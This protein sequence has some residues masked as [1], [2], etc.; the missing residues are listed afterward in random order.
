MLN[1]ND[2]VV[3]ALELIDAR[4]E[5]FDRHTRAPRQVL[6]TARFKSTGVELTGADTAKIAAVFRDAHQLYLELQKH[7]G[8]AQIRILSMGM[9]ADYPIAVAEGANLVRIGTYLFEEGD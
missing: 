8:A 3:P 6:A 4:I 5:Q 9:S 1:A 7:Y 2:Y